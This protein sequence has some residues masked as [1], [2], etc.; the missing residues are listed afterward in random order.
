MDVGDALN[1]L[2][3]SLRDVVELVLRKGVGPEWLASVGLPEE[4]VNSW[5]QRREEEPRRRP[6]GEVEQRLL[7]YADFYGV[8]DLIQKHW[9]KGFHECFG[10]RKRFDVYVDRLGAF[11]NPDAHSRALLPFEQNLVIGMAGELRQEIGLFL[12]RGGGAD[13][14]EYFAR[15]EEVRDSYGMRVVG[16][17]ADQSGSGRSNVTLRPGDEISFAGKAWDPDGRDL[18]WEI[19]LSNRKERIHL[20]GASIEWQW[21]LETRDIGEESSV[22]FAVES[23]RPYHRHRDGLDDRVV[24]WYR[25]LPAIG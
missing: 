12:S 24:M 25:V 15:I 8:V 13:E 16:H 21:R 20:E 6:G 22:L 3:N 14:P 2:E 23:G 1:V 7:Y 17:G 4:R 5:R 18:K 11:R 19:F 9:A 10:N